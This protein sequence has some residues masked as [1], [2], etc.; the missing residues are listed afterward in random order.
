MVKINE[1]HNMDIPDEILPKPDFDVAADLMIFMRNDPMFYRKSFFPAV[2]QY[3]KNTKNTTP[4][5]SMIKQGLGQYCTKF[6]IQNPVNELMGS[7]DVKALVAEIIADEMQ[8]L[9][10][11][12]MDRVRGFMNADPLFKAWKRI[13]N[14]QG[15]QAALRYL[16][17]NKSPDKH[18]EFKAMIG[19]N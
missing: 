17:N 12:I 18:N 14:S 1:F 15:E 9:E 19:A 16:V 2:E 8:D 6:N 4:L 10:E 13:Y 5:E 7:G 3:K 11:G